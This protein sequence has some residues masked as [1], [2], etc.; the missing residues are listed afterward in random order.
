M[1]RFRRDFLRLAGSAVVSGSALTIGANDLHAQAKKP[2]PKERTGFFD[3]R[4]Y[5]ATGDGVTIDTKAINAAIDAANHAGGGTVYFPPG[6]YASYSIHLKSNVIIYLEQGCTIVAAESPVGGATSGAYDLA[7]P[8]GPWEKY[9]EFGHNHF[10][11]SLIWGEDISNI[12]IVGPGLIWGKGLSRGLR[13]HQPLAE[14][15]GVG[16]K[17][18]ALRN[19]HNVIFRDFSVLQG[20][21]FA[22]LVTGVDN[23]TVDNLKIDTNRDGMDIVCCRNVRVSN[24]SINSPWDDAICPKSQYILGY[25]R[26]TENLTIT[27]CYVT[28]GYELGTM[29]DGTWK[30]LPDDTPIPRTGRIKCG[31]ESNA[32]FKNITISNCV[33]ELSRGFALETV[34]GALAEDITF[35]G[36]TMRECTNTPIFMRLGARMRAPS[37][38]PIGSL[39]RVIISNVVSYNSQSM[40]AGGGLIA[41][42]PGHLIEDVKLNELYLEHVGGGTPEMA[43]IMPAEDIK[44]Y[45]DPRMFGNLPAS[46]FFVRHAK[47]IEFS[48]IELAWSKPDAR[49]AFWMQGIDGADIFRLKLPRGYGG[50]AF[51]LRD[52]SDFSVSG[53]RGLKDLY[54]DKVEEK[55]W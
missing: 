45:P 44:R 24:C 36:I 30:R 17:S 40:F 5:G 38:L 21:H 16:N 31:T 7:E 52:V 43:A 1:D 18:I 42:I 50:P 2:T 46:G 33:F 4:V 3:V 25:L 47:N 35:T 49:P 32:G 26:S 22:I 28:G 12:G 15:P 41:G 13:N 14:T 11:N 55:H 54:L 8:N 51:S 48:N 19:A 53:S 10:H 27:N 29:L 23:L 20:G 6:T 39:K 9:Q 37:D 34:D